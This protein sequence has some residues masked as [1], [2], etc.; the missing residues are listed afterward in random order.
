MKWFYRIAQVF[1]PGLICDRARPE[2]ASELVNQRNVLTSIAPSGRNPWDAVPRSSGLG[3]AIEKDIRPERE[4][5]LT[6]VW[7]LRADH[8]LGRPLRARPLCRPNQG[9]N[10]WA[11][12]LN[13]FMVETTLKSHAKSG[14]TLTAYCLLLTDY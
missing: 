3:M 12:L 1:T 6:P 14:R 2:R 8:H 10:A 11:V 13:H 9:V 5:D 7:L 4:A